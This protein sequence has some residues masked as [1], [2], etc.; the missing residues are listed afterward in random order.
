LE[1]EHGPANLREIGNATLG[2]ASL[3]FGYDEGWIGISLCL[4]DAHFGDTGLSAFWDWE[5]ILRSAVYDPRADVILRLRFYGL[6]PA[7]I[8][9]FKAGMP[10]LSTDLEL[11][12]RPRLRT[13]RGDEDG[14][15]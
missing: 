11:E 9:R 1:S 7:Q 12:V 15:S 2:V 13:W 6:T 4:S 8:A 5:Q 3:R 10:L 14:G